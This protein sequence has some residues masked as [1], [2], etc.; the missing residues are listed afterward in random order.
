VFLEGYN[1]SGERTNAGQV[2]PATF[3]VTGPYA[4]ALMKSAGITEE[5]FLIHAPMSD[6]KPEWQ[7]WND[8]YDIT[9][10]GTPY[11]GYE[12]STVVKED[13]SVFL[14]TMKRTLF[15]LN[16]FEQRMREV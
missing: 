3:V 11:E 5:L 6:G 13:R 4:W 16:D 10:E 14:G 15:M 8:V 2:V 9:W 7:N 1:D 12:D